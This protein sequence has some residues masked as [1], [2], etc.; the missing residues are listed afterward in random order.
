MRPHRVSN[1]AALPHSEPPGR[2]GSSLD[3][4]ATFA[5]W[6]LTSG[7]IDPAYPVLAQI[8]QALGLDEEMAVRLVFLYVEFYDLHTALTVWMEAGWPETLT[9]ATY[10]TGT[11]RRAHRDPRQLRRHHE[12]IQARIDGSGS[13]AAWA[14]MALTEDPADSWRTCRPTFRASTATAGGPPTKPARS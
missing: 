3:D 1:P 6:H 10:R 9:K 4:L 13:L 12:A 11:E 7:D 14:K 2:D 8:V 5:R